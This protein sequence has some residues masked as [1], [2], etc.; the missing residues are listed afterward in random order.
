MTFNTRSCF[1]LSHWKS[2]L[3]FPQPSLI[4]NN[5]VVNITKTQ[6]L[7][8]RA[9]GGEVCECTSRNWGSPWK[10]IGREGLRQGEIYQDVP[11]ILK[12]ALWS[13]N[14]LFSLSCFFLQAYVVLGQFLVLRKDE[15]LFR[16]WLKDTCGANTKQQGDCYGCLRE[17]C[18]SF[19]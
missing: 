7:C 1:S 16:E 9:H 14:W 5:N 8:G 2:Q 6:G 11:Y 4:Q 10:E 13:W 12:S 18:D 17:W 15:E 3:E 19:L